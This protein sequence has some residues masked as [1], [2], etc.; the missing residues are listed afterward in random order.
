[1]VR[2]H[3]AE[4]VRGRSPD[5]PRSACVRLPVV[6]AFLVLPALALPAAGADWP[7]FRGP[8]RDGTSPETGLLP[9]WP[10]GG[11]PRVAALDGV[12]EGFSSPAVADGRV[13]VTGR[14]KDS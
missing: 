11:P 10:E 13:F 2:T 4:L 5:P 7:Q 1:M 6:L 12:G 14:V 8:N 9:S 3:T